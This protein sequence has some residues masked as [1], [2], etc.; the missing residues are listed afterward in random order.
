MAAATEN[1]P[2][3]LVFLT[4]AAHLLASSSPQIS[5]HLMSQRN[6]LMTSTGLVVSDAQ[7]QHACTACGHIMV[8]GRADVLRLDAHKAALRKRTKPRLGPASRKPAQS[9]SSSSHGAGGRKRLDCAMCTSYTDIAVPP[10][11]K[12]SRR[13]PATASHASRAAASAASALAPNATT[14]SAATARAPSP[15]M[16]SEPAKSSVNASSKKRAKSRK[17]GLQALLQQSRSSTP[18][19]GLGLSLADFMK[20]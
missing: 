6:S 7:R 5:A 1:L 2:A 15:V 14:T 18:Q 9:S 4:D 19:S 11:P 13:R 8:P 16:A 10:A 17:Q 12:I 3:S 20:K